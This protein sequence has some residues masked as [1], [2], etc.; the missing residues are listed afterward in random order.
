MRSAGSFEEADRRA[1]RNFGAAARAAGVRRIIY[2]GGLAEERAPLSPHLK[3][4]HEVGTILRSSGVPVLEFRASIILGSGSLSFEMI[5]ALVDRLPVMV[6]PRWV[7]VPARPIAIQDVL[8]YLLAALD[9]P[10]DGH[11]NYEIGGRSRVAY[12][13]L[14]KEYARQRG[15]RRR[16]IPVPVLTPRLSSPWLGLVTPLYVRVGRELIESIHPERG[17]LEDESRGS[18]RIRAESNTIGPA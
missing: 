6:T 17:H 9:H 4:R 11:R 18:S 15:L 5:R 16:I 3:S 13:D 10:V 14:M 12:G 8:D 1:A 7:C 2:L